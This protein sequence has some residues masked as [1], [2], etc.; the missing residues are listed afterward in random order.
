MNEAMLLDG[1]ESPADLRKLAPEQLELFRSTEAVAAAA[2][3]ND[4]PGVGHAAIRP[5]SMR[6][7]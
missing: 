6:P 1:I 7:I 4:S 2:G 5:K 3:Y